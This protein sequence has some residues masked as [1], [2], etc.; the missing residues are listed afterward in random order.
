[1]RIVLGGLM[2]DVAPWK[3]VSVAVVVASVDLVGAVVGT[4][5]SVISSVGP[6]MGQCC[7]TF[8]GANHGYHLGVLMVVG[9]SLV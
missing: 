5:A 6:R 8:V 9:P 4:P 7:P 3:R 2:M 1:M